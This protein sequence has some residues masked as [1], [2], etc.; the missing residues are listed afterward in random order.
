M[1]VEIWQIIY[2]VVILLLIGLVR[3]FFNDS[4]SQTIKIFFSVYLSHRTFKR[5]AI[6]YSQ[7]N[8]LASL[9]FFLSISFMLYKV[10]DYYLV[11]TLWNGISNVFIILL[12]YALF[13]YLKIIVYF[14]LGF[15]TGTKD[16][17]NEYLY[18]W[19]NI[20][21]VEGIVLSVISVA[22]AFT[23]EQILPFFIWMGIFFWVFFYSYR[24]V[25]GLKIIFRK[26]VPSFYILL[27]LCTLEF[28]PTLVLYH[29]L[30]K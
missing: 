3:L 4:I 21:H 5:G 17:T 15:I 16:I 29:L 12:A 20:N 14:F 13:T 30:G 1:E 26:K 8:I 10:N 18:N 28:L 23:N 9:L 24:I 22:L 7:Y 19:I 25:R 2:I 6:I 11:L 27:Y